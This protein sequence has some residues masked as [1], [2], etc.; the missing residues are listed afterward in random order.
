[1]ITGKGLTKSVPARDVDE[2]LARVPKD[3]RETLEKLRKTIKAAAPR[4]VEVISYQIPTFKVDGR[5]LVSF[6]ACKH[7]CSFFPGAAPIKEHEYDLKSYVTSKGTI[8][9]AIGKPLPATLVRKLVKARLK[10]NE[11]HLAK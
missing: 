8:R 5:M 11:A 9:F 2:Y 7:H 1:M 6:A 10:Q 4:A 3:A